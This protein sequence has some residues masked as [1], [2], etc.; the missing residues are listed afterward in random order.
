MQEQDTVTLTML[1]KHAGPVCEEQ[2]SSVIPLNHSAAGSG[3]TQ[4]GEIG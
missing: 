3:N 1:C 4:A 2:K